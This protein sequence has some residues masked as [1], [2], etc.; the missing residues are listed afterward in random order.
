MTEKIKKISIFT[1]SQLH[2]DKIVSAVDELPNEIKEWACDNVVI[3]APT[4]RPRMIWAGKGGSNEVL[5]Q[6]ENF[7]LFPSS[8]FDA[9]STYLTYVVAHEIAHAYL[10]HEKYDTHDGK[11]KINDEIEADKLALEWIGSEYK[12]YVDL[13]LKE[14][15]GSS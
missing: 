4:I 1:G 12:Y 2:A 14:L 10:G 13:H 3:I 5:L 6:R 15:E 8:V 7:I 9:D 11:S